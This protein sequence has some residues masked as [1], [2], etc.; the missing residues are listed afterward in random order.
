MRLCEKF[1]A[2]KREAVNIA[3]GE[4]DSEESIHE[5]GFF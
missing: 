2:R 3:V 5:L 1:K 4:Y